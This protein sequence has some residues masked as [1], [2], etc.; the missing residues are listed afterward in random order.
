MANDNAGLVYQSPELQIREAEKDVDQAILRLASTYAAAYGLDREESLKIQDTLISKVKEAYKAGTEKMRQLTELRIEDA[1]C[2]FTAYRSG[3]PI[4]GHNPG[5]T[6]WISTTQR[7]IKAG[8]NGI[9]DK[10]KAEIRDKFNIEDSNPDNV[11]V[12][13]R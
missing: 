2:A 3:R 5:S 12:S 11:Q 7:R 1:I 10:W 8:W 4:D 6:H 13:L 9:P